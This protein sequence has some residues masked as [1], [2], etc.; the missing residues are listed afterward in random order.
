MFES[1]RRGDGGAMTAGH[2]RPDV[3]KEHN[4]S[5]DEFRNILEILGRE[6]TSSSSASSR[7]CGASTARTS[8][9]ASTCASSRRPGR[10]SS[11]APA[12]TPASST[13][14][15][16]LAVFFKMESHNHP[17]FI[18]PYQGAATGRRRHPARRL[19]DGRAADRLASNSLRFGRLDAPR[20][21]RT[22]STASSPAS[23][24]TATHS[25]SRRVGGE[26]DLRQGLRRQ[27]PR[28]RDDRRHRRAPTASSTA[29]AEGVGNPVLYVG[30]QDRPRRHPRRDDGLRR[31][32]RRR[33]EA[34]APDRAG[35]R[36]LHREAP[37]RG[38]PRALRRR[39]R[40]SA[41]RTWAPRG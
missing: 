3:I 26:I 34:E 19:H 20:M 14:A 24:A 18:E 8:P 23:P 33:G 13:S 28:Q 36:S 41:S 31:V 12:R 4:L 17:S 38:V 10:A 22:S 9:R 25:A 11:R 7:R 6:P 27:H 30:I 5:A 37:P 35:R 29:R 39:T 40:S 32:R 2:H 16:G 21:T 1:R 15:T